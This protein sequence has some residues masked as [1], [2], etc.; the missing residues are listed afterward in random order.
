MQEFME[1]YGQKLAVATAQ[2][3]CFVLLP[4][5]F[6]IVVGLTL[7]ALLSRNRK[8]AGFIIPIISVFQTIPGIVFLGLLML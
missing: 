1:K 7:A 8:A 6:A 4:V 3:V 5:F 2:H